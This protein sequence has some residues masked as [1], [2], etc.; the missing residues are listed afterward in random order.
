MDI[1]EIAALAAKNRLRAEELA[2]AKHFAEALPYISEAVSQYREL[3][4][5]SS[6]VDRLA[7]SE[8]LKYSRQES[9]INTKDIRFVPFADR[10]ADALQKFA[11]IS[12][13][14]SEYENAKEHA[15]EAV[16]VLSRAFE[17]NREAYWKQLANALRIHSNV[18]AASGDLG[19]ALLQAFEAVAIFRAHFSSDTSSYFEFLETLATQLK[20]SAKLGD[21]DNIDN[22]MR[23]IFS[24]QSSLHDYES[25]EALLSAADTLRDTGATLS[26][27]GYRSEAKQILKWALDE[28]R[29]LEKR[30]LQGIRF[31]IARAMSDLSANY[32]EIGAYRDALEMA[33]QATAIYRRIVNSPNQEDSPDLFRADY[34][35]ALVNLSRALHENGKIIDAIESIRV[36]STIFEDLVRQ[37][38]KYIGDF[39][40]SAISAL[41]LAQERNLDLD[42]TFID[43]VDYVVELLVE[44]GPESHDLIATSMN[45]LGSILMAKGDYLRAQR[46]FQ[47][48]LALHMRYDEEYSYSSLALLNNLGNV[49]KLM[50]DTA[51]ALEFYKQSHDISVRIFG[52]GNRIAI[53]SANNLA[54]AL[55][56][57]GDTQS[58][59]RLY[60]EAISAA[61]KFLGDDHEYVDILKSNLGKIK[62]LT[63]GHSGYY[64]Q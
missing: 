21:K 38:T 46:Y 62:D 36:A 48:A 9:R 47:R 33:Q 35:R 29:H 23:D 2:S 11:V 39:L 55:E 18:Q 28:Y 34:A 43:S 12:L 30:D 54:L 15:A 19:V 4:L 17:I 61:I 41:S 6:D 58:A 5:N 22:T 31:K 8:W 26:L 64:M 32:S 24:M 44:F 10:F 25:S 63:D 52:S 20:L 13:A 49:A 7:G 59:A 42:D 60:N 56:E 45:N 1:N 16:K 40:S 37:D 50:G 53:A 14:L 51:S 27:S 57:K 3:L